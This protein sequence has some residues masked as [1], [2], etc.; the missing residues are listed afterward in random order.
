MTYA[1]IYEIGYIASVSLELCL[2]YVKIQS[3]QEAVHG[4][5]LGIRRS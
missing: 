3:E 1:Y 2:Y 4:D 5:S